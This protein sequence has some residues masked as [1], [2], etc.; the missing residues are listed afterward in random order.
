[1]KIERGKSE[2]VKGRIKKKIG[3]KGA[4]KRNNARNTHLKIT[5]GDP[6]RNYRLLIIGFKLF[7]DITFDNCNSPLRI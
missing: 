1:M 3:K 4:R 6:V 7:T 5:M 2:R